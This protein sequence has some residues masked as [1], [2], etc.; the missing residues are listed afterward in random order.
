MYS[1]ELYPDDT[2]NNKI[3]WRP[4]F[5]QASCLS[6]EFLKEVRKFRTINGWTNAHVL[7][8]TQLILIE[9]I[10]DTTFD[11]AFNY[12]ALPDQ[13]SPFHGTI[14]CL[15]YQKYD[16]EPGNLGKVCWVIYRCSIDSNHISNWTE[17]IL[18]SKKTKKSMQVLK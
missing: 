6:P 11:Y 9:A 3:F 4:Q 13:L 7:A 10:R 1:T 2:Y 8:L 12:N 16:L 15:L 18:F 14:D 5:Y 17:I